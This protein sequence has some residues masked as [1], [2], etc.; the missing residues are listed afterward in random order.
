MRD[1]FKMMNESWPSPWNYLVRVHLAQTLAC[2]IL[3]GF[4]LYVP[5]VTSDEVVNSILSYLMIVLIFGIVIQ[6]GFANSAR[7]IFLRLRN[8]PD[9]NLAPRSDIKKVLYFPRA[10]SLITIVVWLGGALLF[11][12]YASTDSNLVEVRSLV[13]PL[14]VCGCGLSWIAAM[15]TFYSLSVFTDRTVAPLLLADGTLD[16]LGDIRFIRLFH[17]LTGLFVLYVLAIPSTLYGLF[18]IAEDPVYVI[19]WCVGPIVIL[20]LWH[21]LLVAMSSSR[22]LGHIGSVMR[23]IQSGNLS[24]KATVS[25]LDGCGELASG[26]NAMTHGLRQRELLRETFGRYLSQQVAEAVLDGKVNLGGERHVAT[27]LFSDIRGFTS[28][29]ER[30][31]P[32]EVVVFLNQYL[33]IMVD[34]VLEHG[35]IIDKFI[36]D[37]IMAVFGVPVSQ[38][39][40]A[41]DATAAVAC[42]VQ[43]SERLDSFNAERREL[44]EDQVNIGIAVHTGPL[45]AGN[46]GSSA[47][48]EYTVIGDTVNV[49]SRIEGM[50]KAVGKRVLISE[51]TAN[52]LNG[53]IALARV[54]T[55]PIRGREQSVDL[56]TLED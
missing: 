50:T 44:G 1:V 13:V 46:I 42:A 11:P 51:V 48:M 32:E 36:G 41:T 34:C 54:A 17:H 31:E 55:A 23:E 40:T 7:S 43:M 28:M 52:L 37:A 33:E 21:I 49:A 15:L 35:G 6:T 12:F 29:S 45:V 24:C 14:T 53:Q 16:G 47:K 4:F 56:F 18:R 8:S 3:I 5:L 10:A 25:G 9:V 38:G 2:I 26:L 39:E 22:P 20:L 30:L 19:M 27:V